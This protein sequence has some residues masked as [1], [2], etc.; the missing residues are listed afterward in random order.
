[1]KKYIF[2]I[3]GFVV[4]IL[5]TLVL[6]IGLYEQKNKESIYIKNE[7]K[8]IAKKYIE[9]ENI[10]ISKEGITISKEDLIDKQY[11][12]E[13]KY[14]DKTCF[15]LIKVNKVLIFNKYDISYS[16]EITNII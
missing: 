13:V 16:C 7:F 1:M 2:I 11:D 5:C 8:E 12:Y 4:A 15:A 10:E 14:E 6:Y 3:W 9:L